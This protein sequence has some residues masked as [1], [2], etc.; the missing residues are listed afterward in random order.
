M[1]D[2]ALGLTQL[3][4]FLFFIMLGFPIAF[5]LMAMGL[6]FVP[7]STLGFATLPPHLRVQGATISNLMPAPQAAPEGS[8]LTA[9][10]PTEGVDATSVV[11]LLVTDA[12]GTYQLII[13]APPGTKSVRI[14]PL[15]AVA[16][17]N[18]GLFGR[19]IA[20]ADNDDTK[21]VYRRAS[22]SPEFGVHF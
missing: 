22:G 9:A 11:R 2:G 7:M 1:S 13:D 18:A 20:L 15:P 12:G 17:A 3:F 10:V 16:R 8:S 5:T 4:L 6:F 19:V 21:G 14:P